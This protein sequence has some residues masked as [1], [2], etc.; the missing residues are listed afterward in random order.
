MN[1]LE[2]FNNELDVT[3][4]T[5]LEEFIKKYNVSK[6]RIVRESGL[7]KEQFTNVIMDDGW[8]N[9][10]FFTLPKDFKIKLYGSNQQ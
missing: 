9:F 8:E 2:Q 5:S 7:T 3:Q 6:E 1:Y 4:C 10:E